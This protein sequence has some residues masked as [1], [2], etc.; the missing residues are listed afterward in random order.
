MSG[1]LSDHLF[2]QLS[3][4]VASAIGL[5][6]P[7]E[8]ASDLQRGIQLAA[9]EG[10]FKDA[11]ECVQWLM[12]APLTREQIE[13]LASHLT[14]GETYF[15]REKRAFEVLEEQVLPELIRLRRGGEQRLRIW[16]A[17]CCS[18]EE[19]Y[20]IAISL[21]KLLPDLADW[22]V[23]ILGTDINPR[24]LRKASQG[25]FGEWSFRDT[26][27]GFKERHFKKAIDGLWEI[28]PEIRKMVTFSHLN[29][30]EDAYPSLL[31]NTN[32]IDLVFC[33]NVL[34]YFAP[35]QAR[36]AI[37]NLA[38][39]LRG[40]GWLVLGPNEVAQADLPDLVP[41][42]FPGATLFRKDSSR[43]WPGEVRSP[44]WEEDPLAFSAPPIE[45]VFEPGAAMPPPPGE[46]VPLETTTI[47]PP[48]PSS[49][50]QSLAFFEQGRYAET[51]ETLAEIAS[52][53]PAEPRVLTLLARALANQGKLAEALVWCDKVIA[54]DKLNPGSHYLRASIL[55]EQG[56]LSEAVPAFKRALYLDPDF[57]LAHFAL[58]NLARSQGKFAEADKHFKNALVLARG[59]SPEDLLPEAEGL[60]AGRLAEIITALR[61]AFNDPIIQ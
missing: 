46:R 32:A 56:D 5:H 11:T 20:S 8:R 12:S 27:H 14:V 61:E 39:C 29:L 41:M 26:P 9:R 3:E 4:F 6:F 57:V 33:R 18:G 13:I 38:H 53:E 16:S 2:S 19:P 40:G 58:G 55:Q 49:Y 42:R 54:S 50:E 48:P 10:G 1:S 7:P 15:F 21:R 23:T 25:V 47:E 45:A 60:T 59:H 17:A 43:P 52:R 51:V 30:A 37:R 36:R 24:F 22:Q 34:I 35:E 44:R 28:L 31:N